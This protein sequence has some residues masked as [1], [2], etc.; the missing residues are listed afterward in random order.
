[1]I[2]RIKQFFC[3]HTKIK[4]KIKIYDSPTSTILIICNCC[5][6]EIGSTLIENTLYEELYTAYIKFQAHL[7]IEGYASIG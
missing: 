7:G 5:D 2:N 6:K 4:I 3:F 1:M